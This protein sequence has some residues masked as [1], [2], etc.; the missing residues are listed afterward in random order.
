MYNIHSHTQNP[1]VHVEH[2]SWGSIW[3]KD[4]EIE[5]DSVSIWKFTWIYAVHT[6]DSVVHKGSNIV[7]SGSWC[8][9]L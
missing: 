2:K 1:Q 3:A 5:N 9:V 8:L 4:G 7:L 6:R